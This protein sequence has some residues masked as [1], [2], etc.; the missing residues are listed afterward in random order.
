MFL[1]FWNPQ[2][3]FFQIQ[4]LISNHAHKRI[5]DQRH[6]PNRP[7]LVPFCTVGSL[8]VITLLKPCLSLISWLGGFLHTL[9][10]PPHH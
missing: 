5:E 6:L 3:V 4:A 10:F 2:D 9:N 8:G 7:D 1:H